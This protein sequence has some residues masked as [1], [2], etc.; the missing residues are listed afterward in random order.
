MRLGNKVNLQITTVEWS[1]PDHVKAFSTTRLGGYSHAPFGGLNLG[2]HVRDNPEH[3]EKKQAS[4]ESRT[5]V[6][7][8]TAMA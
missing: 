3:V 8:S 5:S 1:A 7:Q 2:Q 6:A 4:F